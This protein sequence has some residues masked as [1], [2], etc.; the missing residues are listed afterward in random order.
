MFSKMK[1]IELLLI[2]LMSGATLIT[3][4]PLVLELS[5][6]HVPNKLE[7]LIAADEDSLYTLVSIYS[8]K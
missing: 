3:R 4:Y 7:Q 2:L 5:L 1:Y 8:L 6:T